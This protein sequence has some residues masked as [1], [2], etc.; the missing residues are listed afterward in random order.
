[1][2]SKEV[3]WDD[4]ERDLYFD[5]LEDSSGRCP[6]CDHLLVESADTNADPNNPEAKYKYQT[7]NP[8]VCW[9]CEAKRHS[10]DAWRKQWPNLEKATFFAV[11]RRIERS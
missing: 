4:E 8:L 11:T 5:Y 7:S 6:G 3:E 10:T 2:T 1:V 9:S